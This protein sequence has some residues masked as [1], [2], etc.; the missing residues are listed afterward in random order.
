[1][2]HEPSELALDA[3]RHLVHAVSDSKD[4]LYV[5]LLPAPADAGE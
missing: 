3:A 5:Y 4:R 1:V 2:D